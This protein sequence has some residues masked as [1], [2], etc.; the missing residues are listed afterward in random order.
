MFRFPSGA[1]YVVTDNV[2][3]QIV[4][5]NSVEESTAGEDVALSVWI[6]KS[7]KRIPKKLNTSVAFW[8]CGIACS[9]IRPCNVLQLTWQQLH[10]T[11]QLL[12]SSE[13]IC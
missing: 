8:A 5:K 13:S 2:A 9:P 11:M 1:G 3:K 7:L 10:Q 12:L 6:N 4:I